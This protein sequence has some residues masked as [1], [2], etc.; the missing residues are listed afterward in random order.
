M[1]HQKDIKE[2]AMVFDALGHEARLLVFR[3]LVR[4]GDDGLIVSEIQKHL[5]L[6]PSTLAHHLKSLVNSGLATQERV[7]NQI[8]NRPNFDVLTHTLRFLLEEC[9]EGVGLSVQA[10]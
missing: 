10:A 8:V 4:A 5:Q 1:D 6:P 3:L 7:G 2:A 9:C